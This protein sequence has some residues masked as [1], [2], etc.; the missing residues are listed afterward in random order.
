MAHVH[1]HNCKYLLSSLSSY[2]DGELEARLC[3]ELE[4]HLE[5]CENCRVVVDSLQKTVSLYRE[6]NAN[7]ECPEDIRQR[8]FHTLNLD[9]FMKT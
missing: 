1:D 3:A 5:D 9:E 2:I 8:L 4:R 7:V 6:S